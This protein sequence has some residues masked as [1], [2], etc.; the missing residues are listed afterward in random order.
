MFLFPFGQER[1]TGQFEFSLVGSEQLGGLCRE[2]QGIVRLLADFVVEDQLGAFGG[3]AGDGHQ[4][5][6]VNGGCL[7]VSHL[8]VEHRCQIAA[9]VDVHVFQ[10]VLASESLAGIFHISNVMSVPH[11]VYGIDFGESYLYADGFTQCHI[12][13]P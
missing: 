3:A 10:A 11:H 7:V 5:D 13:P 1:R 6:V 9:V 12:S 4:Q 8:D 2:D